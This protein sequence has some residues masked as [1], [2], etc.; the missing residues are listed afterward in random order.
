MA[1][2]LLWIARRT[3]DGQFPRRDWTDANPWEARSIVWASEETWEAAHR[4]QVPYV[5]ISGLG[6]AV[7]AVVTL[8]AVAAV[9]TAAASDVMLAAVLGACAW[10][11]VW[12]VVGHVV[13]TRAAREVLA[14]A[15]RDRRA[16]D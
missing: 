7:A 8:V 9:G 16:R 3:T 13:G 4:A 14:R 12:F 6:F 5:R 1:L 15:D 2:M 11:L 10:G